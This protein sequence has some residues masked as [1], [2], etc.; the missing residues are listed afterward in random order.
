MWTELSAG[1]FSRVGPAFPAEKLLCE[2][3][4]PEVPGTTGVP[5]GL[6]RR[7][8]MPAPLRSCVV[9]GGSQHVGT[10]GRHKRCLRPPL[11]S[12]SQLVWGVAWP[13]EV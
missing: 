8:S 12:V 5:R 1:P 10:W 9:R 7:V 3:A 13:L 6:C 2:K 11:S 4:L